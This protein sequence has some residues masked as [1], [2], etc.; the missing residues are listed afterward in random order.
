MITASHALAQVIGLVMSLHVSR[1]A[2]LRF[3]A[4]AEIRTLRGIIHIC[5]SCKKIGDDRGF[6]HQVERYISDRSDADFTHGYCP[7]CLEDFLSQAQAE[8]EARG[9]VSQ[10]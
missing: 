8:I 4:F 2:R 5:A 10:S 6:W 7:T 3:E 9:A 1:T